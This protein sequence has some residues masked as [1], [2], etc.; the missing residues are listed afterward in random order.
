MSESEDVQEV[1]RARRLE[2]VNSA[3]TVQAAIYTEENGNVAM[4]MRDVDGRP[5]VDI[6]AGAQ[7]MTFITLHD[8][9]GYERLIASV[10]A[11]GNVAISL[12]DEVGD[13]RLFLSS[14]SQG[15][16]QAVLSNDKGQPKAAARLMQDGTVQAFVVDS[17]GTPLGTVLKPG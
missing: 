11:D 4:Q 10:M 14:H 3:G 13:P 17:E 9:K 16:T 7:G 6:I 5:R 8:G 1:V 12:Q 2:I 15:D